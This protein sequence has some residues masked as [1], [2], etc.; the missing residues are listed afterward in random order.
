MGSSSLDLTVKNYLCLEETLTSAIMES[1]DTDRLVQKQTS[2]Q[3]DQIRAE[4]APE[5]DRIK[6]E[7]EGLDKTAQ[8]DEYQDLL[9]ELNDLVEERQDKIERLEDELHMKETDNQLK[10]ESDQVRLEEVKAQ[11]ES[12]EEMRKE[13]IENEFGYFN[14]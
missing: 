13:A 3:I 10:R 8:K 6:N 11:R 14:N 9:R 12:F 7:I 1:S 2:A 4:Y 5:E